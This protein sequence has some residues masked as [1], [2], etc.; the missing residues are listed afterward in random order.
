MSLSN[1]NTPV[2][3][4]INRPVRYDS[5]TIG[6]EIVT[7]STSDA[8]T[9]TTLNAAKDLVFDYRGTS[10][11]VSVNS[12]RSGF[13]MRFKFKTKGQVSAAL[14]D[15]SAADTTLVNNFWA[16][17]FSD[18]SL[19]VG[20]SDV[21]SIPN[22][23]IVYDARTALE[24]DTFRHYGSIAG[25][26]PDEKDGAADDPGHD[27]RKQLYNYTLPGNAAAQNAAYRN[28]E[29]FV[30]LSFVSGFCTSFNRL[31]TNL[32]YRFT[33]R[34]NGNTKNAFSGANGTE[35][36]LQMTSIQLELETFDPAAGLKAEYLG[37]VEKSKDIEVAFSAYTSVQN[38]GVTTTSS[39]FSESQ[40]SQARTLIVC[41]KDT[42]L[43]DSVTA[44]YG[45][46]SHA[47]ITE[48]IHEV[49]TR[50]YPNQQQEG[51]FSSNIFA[52]FYR[53][54]VDAVMKEHGSCGLSALQFKNLYP[55]FAIDVSAQEPAP[56]N[57]P[58]NI[59]TSI[60][61]RT[62]TPANVDLYLIICYERHFKIDM[63][64]DSVTQA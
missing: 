40:F 43:R 50:K 30:P 31:T 42:T 60:K 55:F 38:A 49:Q 21:E 51:D 7:V 12:F 14:A 58:L 25:F 56:N 1:P 16:H 61:R 19:K 45:V 11:L 17:L 28:V 32:S 20:S 53:D 34:R 24:S 36:I 47:D 9:N 22:F 10:S 27:R 5:S 37:V 29:I 52:A 18:F 6:T 8:Q 35:M 46:Y 48:I 33:L 57:K 4:K 62:A 15:L 63:K 41:A 59:K 26:M 39:T 64:R 54:T 23:G 13:R 2:F 3:Y 44:N